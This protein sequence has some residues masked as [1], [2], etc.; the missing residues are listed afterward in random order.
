M[1]GGPDDGGVRRPPR[2]RRV[3]DGGQWRQR[4]TGRGRGP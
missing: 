4:I 1:H 3:A 2:A